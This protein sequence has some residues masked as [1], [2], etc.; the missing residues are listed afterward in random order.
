MNKKMKMDAS[1]EEG[2]L[3]RMEQFTRD[4]GLIILEMELEPRSGQMD[5]NTMAFGVKT[6]P[7]VKESLSTLMA[8]FMKASG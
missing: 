5:P 1:L 3:S 8:M 7:T 6:K 2:S 4:S